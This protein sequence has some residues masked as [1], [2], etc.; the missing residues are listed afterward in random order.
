[1]QGLGEIDLAPVSLFSGVC[2]QAEAF[3]RVRLGIFDASFE[4]AI[5]ATRGGSQ[6]WSGDQ[7]GRCGFT[8]G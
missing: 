6:A 4:V 7:I 5:V 2:L 3:D 8:P 1:M